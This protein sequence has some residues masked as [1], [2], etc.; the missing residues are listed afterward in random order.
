MK[1]YNKKQMADQFGLSISTIRKYDDEGIF[2]AK[3]DEKGNRYYTEDDVEKLREMI[4]FHEIGMEYK[5]DIVPLMQEGVYDRNKVLEY[6]IRMLEKKKE[7]IDRQIA[8]AR[9]VQLTGISYFGVDFGR[10][11]LKKDLSRLISHIDLDMF[12][13][14]QK[15]NAQSLES[16]G[17]AVMRDLLKLAALWKDSDEQDELS[18]E[19]AD[20][21]INLFESVV[22]SYMEVY[23]DLFGRGVCILLLATLAESNGNFHDLLVDRCG[24]KFTGF[25]AEM[26]TDYWMSEFEDGLLDVYKEALPYLKSR[27]DE[28]PCE[29]LEK[30]K[31]VVE[32]NMGSAELVQMEE[33]EYTAQMCEIIELLLIDN[34]APRGRE[35]NVK[36]LCR[37]LIAKKTDSQK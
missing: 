29:I 3:K 19:T 15:I 22:D 13:R 20:E 18:D 1:R 25:F 4:V 34:D 28:I 21:M 35:R 37:L 12:N 30:C 36:K 32:K 24:S 23:Q 16:L 6:Q 11:G 17:E 10:Q 26:M 27:S 8:F 5:R 14:I 9:I 2:P 31:A 33:A 7:E